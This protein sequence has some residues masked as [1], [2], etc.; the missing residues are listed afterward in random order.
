[1]RLQLWAQDFWRWLYKFGYGL[2]FPWGKSKWNI[3]LNSHL[4]F[5]PR[6]E[7]VERFIHF[8]LYLH[9]M[10]LKHKRHLLLTT[11]QPIFHLWILWQP[12]NWVIRNSS[13]FSEVS[14]VCS[15]PENRIFL[16]QSFLMYFHM[17]QVK[18]G[19]LP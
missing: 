12:F 14:R 1:M 8:T 5:V 4:H 16:Q 18:F 17:L 9:F 19:I 11:S 2:Y 3:N 10:T 6:W 7:Y 15:G 13:S